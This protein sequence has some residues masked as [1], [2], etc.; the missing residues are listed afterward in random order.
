[1][2][3]MEF[4]LR[5]GPISRSIRIL[6]RR[7][8]R[9]IL[10]IAIIQT[11][12]S[13]LDLLG[14]VAIGLLGAVSVSGIQSQPAG[15]QI[16]SL[17]SFIGLQNSTF[18]TQALVLGLLAVALLV[19]RTVLSIFF[20][21]KIIFF[22]SYKAAEISA[23]LVFN[24]LS[25]S[26]ISVQEKTT[27]ATQFAVTRGVDIMMVQVI[28]TCVVMVADVSL[29][30]VMG[31]GLLYADPTTAIGGLILFAIA[32]LI[33]HQ[34]LQVRAGK[35]GI[36]HSDVTVQI[37]EKISEVISSYREIV[38]RNRT[39]YYAREI[40]RLRL[41]FSATSAEMNFLPYVSKHVIETTVIVG[42][43][44]LGCAQFLLND[45]IHAVTTLAI[46]FAA[47]SRIAPAVLR[48][49]QGSMQ[50]RTG[51]G[52]AMPTLELIDR[53]GFS[54][55]PNESP[56]NLNLVHKGFDPEIIISGVTLRYPNSEIAA[57]D[58][59]TLSIA[60]GS[61]VAV[62]GPSGSGKTSLID[63]LLGVVAPDTGSVSISGAPPLEAAKKWPGAISYVP[64]DVVMISG[65]IREN[66][67]LGYKSEIASD[68]I[69]F[70]ALD[71][72]QLKTFVDKL[73]AGLD[74]KI[75]QSGGLISGGERQRLGVARAIFTKPRLLVLDEATSALDSETESGLSAA[76]EKLKGNTT[77]IMIA[78]RLSTVK[79]ADL[80][81]YMENGQVLAK[82]TFD[83][84]RAIIPNFNLQAE[85]MGIPKLIN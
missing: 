38:V 84:V 22:L 21:R 80:V 9:K 53:V 4:P 79:R 20:T 60:A 66:V 50:L 14:V 26:L 45:V 36:K 42:G 49:Q 1:M 47:G 52:Q 31:A 23:N 39:E 30:L 16:N 27:M 83:E 63:I 35:L 12:M 19:G 40:G 51:I 62:V 75:G 70:E 32:G 74:T 33:L 41:D 73:S 13:L 82:G 43:L 71:F 11:L 28:G 24:L 57:L 77:V 54:S 72:A 85:I 76:I 59:V 2:N 64:Q 68:K 37:N 65:T 5:N 46:F 78:H 44:L 10:Y 7:D 29:L 34:V 55:I 48:I 81:V 8:R 69:V 17:L 67:S 3:F 56:N 61:T 18:Q 15:G 6:S 58:N 25:K